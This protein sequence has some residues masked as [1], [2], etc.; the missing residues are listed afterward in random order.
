M[1][2]A[3]CVALPLS[4]LVR[5][6]LSAVRGAVDTVKYARAFVTHCPQ[7][8]AG[9]RADDDERQLILEEELSELPV[10]PEQQPPIAPA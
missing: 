6:P 7:D 5:G 4:A 10:R 1:R 9:L 8:H 2:D 3:L